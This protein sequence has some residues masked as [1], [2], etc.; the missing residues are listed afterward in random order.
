MFARGHRQDTKGR[1]RTSR[2]TTRSG[3]RWALARLWSGL[4]SLEDRVVPALGGLH[5]Y[6]GGLTPNGIGF[7]P[8]A[9]AVGDLNGDAKPDVVVANGRSGISVLLNNGDGTFQAARNF[10]SGNFDVSEVA[11][12]DF[13]G[14]GK[15]DI[16]ACG[17][18]STFFVYHN[19]GD[20]TFVRSDGGFAGTN[21]TSIAVGDLNG[22]GKPDIVMTDAGIQTHGSVGNT[23]VV[24][25]NDGTGHFTDTSP[26][27]L[28]VGNL[29]SAV[30]LAD[31]NHDGHLD[32][33]TANTRDGTVS[34]LLGNGNGTFQGLRNFGVGAQPVAVAVG[35]LNGDRQP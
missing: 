13:D 10:G 5:T 6:A 32:I 20:G 17:H 27:Q 28:Q 16:A 1:T 11:V 33:L 35:D 2:R 4:E 8:N 14:D 19:N 23:V 9:V 34:E 12:G 31:M 30:A 15:L 26:L 7:G 18:D 22:D 3:G 21:L 25:F 24:Y 29:P